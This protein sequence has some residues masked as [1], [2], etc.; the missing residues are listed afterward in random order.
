[1]GDEAA[2]VF[3]LDRSRAIALAATLTLHVVALFWLLALRFEQPVAVILEERLVWLPALPPLPPPLESD[4]LPELDSAP[5]MLPMLRPEVT[6]RVVVPRLRDALGWQQ[7]AR[8][9]ADAVVGKESPYYR[10]GE[11]PKAPTGRPKEEY[12]PSIWAVPSKGRKGTAE[13]TPEGELILWVSDDCYIPLGTQSLTMA[14]IHKAREGVRRCI[15]PLGR[16]K[17]RSDLFEHLKRK[18]VDPFPEKE[19]REEEP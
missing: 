5:V 12:P 8:D 4:Q 15:I 16:K 14:D 1:M 7:D 3:R 10:F 11:F 17:P 2:L 18:P 6:P 19:P 9:A 13:R